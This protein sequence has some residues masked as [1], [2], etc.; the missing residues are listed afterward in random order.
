MNEAERIK[1]IEEGAVRDCY[2]NETDDI[3]LTS[4]GFCEECESC[5]IHFLLGLLRA[6]DKLIEKMKPFVEDAEDGTRCVCHLTAGDC[7]WHKAR[8]LLERIGEV[9]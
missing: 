2:V 5:K 3:G 1:E 8:A 4:E 6:R 9:T 7:E